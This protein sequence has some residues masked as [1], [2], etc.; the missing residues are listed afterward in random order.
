[1]GLTSFLNR[2]RGAV[3]RFVGGAGNIVKKVAD[4]SA[5]IVRKIG[6]IAQPVGGAL[7]SIGDIVGMPQLSAVGGI[8]TKGGQ[9]IANKTDP[10][11]AK[12]TQ[13]ASR[14][15]DTGNALAMG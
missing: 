8:I 15:Q 6:M 1:M 13:I 7:S 14:L 2:T 9:L 10:V 12:A 5:P 3:G 11:V 4:F